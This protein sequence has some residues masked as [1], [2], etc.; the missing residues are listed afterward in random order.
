MR[1]DTKDF[2]V[3]AGEKVSLKEWPTVVKPFYK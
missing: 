2:R 3:R 1:I